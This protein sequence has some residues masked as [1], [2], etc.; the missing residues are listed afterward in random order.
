MAVSELHKNDDNCDIAEIMSPTTFSKVGPSRVQLAKS[1]FSTFSNLFQ[2]AEKLLFNLFQPFPTCKK[3]LFNFS[4]LFPTC[5]KLL[6]NVF[7]TFFNF[8]NLQKVTFKRLKKLFS[9][10][11]SWWLKLLRLQASYQLLFDCTHAP[12][13][14]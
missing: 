5:K 14:L 3:L 12:L 7:P 8:S 6:F 11:H 4:Q 10:L 2:L 1:Y 13:I 9:C